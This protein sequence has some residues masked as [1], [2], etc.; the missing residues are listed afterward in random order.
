MTVDD[1]R[2]GSWHTRAGTSA[3]SSWG[4][5]TNPRGAPL[6]RGSVNHTHERFVVR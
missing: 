1:S 6:W 2:V 4:A 3:A 5:T